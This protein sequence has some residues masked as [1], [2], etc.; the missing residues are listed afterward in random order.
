M[1]KIDIEKKYRDGI[2]KC[3]LF[4]NGEWNIEELIDISVL[5]AKLEQVFR[6]SLLPFQVDIDLDLT[7]E[8]EICSE[9][10][11]LVTVFY[12]TMIKSGIV[13][14]NSKVIYNPIFG[15]ASR[16]CGGAD[17]DIYIDGTLYDF[18]CTKKQDCFRS[19]VQSLRY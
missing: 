7:A 2:E 19:P 15:Q 11:N 1:S 4:V 10:K 13:K 17:A 16:S 6:R 18:K 9:L 8:E 5:F 14:E 3:K 12:N